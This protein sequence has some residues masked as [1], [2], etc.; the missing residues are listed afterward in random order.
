MQAPRSSRLW[1]E[2][3]IAQEWREHVCKGL[4]EESLFSKPRSRCLHLIEDALI[5]SW[6]VHWA[7]S[8]KFVISITVNFPATFSDRSVSF[9]GSK[10]WCGEVSL[11]PGTY[12]FIP[13]TFVDNPG[14]I[15]PYPWC[16]CYDNLPISLSSAWLAL[17]LFGSRTHRSEEA[18]KTDTASGY[19]SSLRT[20]NWKSRLRLNKSPSQTS[21]PLGTSSCIGRKGA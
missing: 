19:D 7:C 1:K 3:F 12:Y 11:I 15:N 21:G 17:L 14:Y 9:S 13:N 2:W 20:N 5:D 8:C 16:L 4:F 18:Q 10:K 6:V